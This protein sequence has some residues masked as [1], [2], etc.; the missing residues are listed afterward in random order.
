MVLRIERER[1]TE[2]DRDR[3]RETEREK[4]GEERRGEE[5]RG[6]E[7]R[8]EKEKTVMYTLSLLS[9]NGS[10][11]LMQT[12]TQPQNLQPSCRINLVSG[13]EERFTFWIG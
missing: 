9:R 1:E 13:N 8:R 10:L 6:E 2:R 7:R 5:R 12:Q 11:E 3:D 4:R